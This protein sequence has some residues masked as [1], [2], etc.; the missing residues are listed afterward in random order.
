MIECA[1]CRAR[2]REQRSLLCTLDIALNDKRSLELPVDFA[3]VVATHA[4]ADMGGVL[5]RAERRLA[6]FWCAILAVSSFILLGTA[7]RDVVLRPA[8]SVARQVVALC[9]M[10][11]RAAYDAGAS[12]AVISRSVGGHL[13]FES[14]FFGAFALLLLIVSVALLPGL[15]IRHRRAK[16]M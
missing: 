4:K 1:S 16:I 12:F 3:R 14:H 2:L 6:L 15:I 8:A 10:A 7:F 9:D 11:G 5:D 13:I